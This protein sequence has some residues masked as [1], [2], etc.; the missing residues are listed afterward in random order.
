VYKRQEQIIVADFEA[1]P[2]TY[3]SRITYISGGIENSY[4]NRQLQTPLRQQGIRE[5]GADI[6]EG[7]K[8]AF[9][10]RRDRYEY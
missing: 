6:L 9:V 8:I 7:G 4:I 2:T 1:V 10:R 5:H 3:K